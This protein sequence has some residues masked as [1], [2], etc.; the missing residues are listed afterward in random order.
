MVTEVEFR[1]AFS[2]A[3]LR[4]FDPAAAATLGL[5]PEESSWLTTVGLPKWAAPSLDFG[6]G[7]ELRLPTVRGLLPGARDLPAEERFRVIGGN[8]SG[9]PVAI[10]V[11]E[12]GAIVYLNHDK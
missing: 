4:T 2:D 8:G 5:P 10:D 12:K 7:S 6:E 3:G 9:D 11:A 1:A